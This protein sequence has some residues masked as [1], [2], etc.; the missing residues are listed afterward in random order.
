ML[1][2]IVALRL[3]LVFVAVYFNKPFNLPGKSSKKDQ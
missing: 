2:K 3:P 1:R